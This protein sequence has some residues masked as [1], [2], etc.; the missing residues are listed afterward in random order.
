MAQAIPTKTIARLFREVAFVDDKTR[1]STRTIELA[2]E[3]L[4]L[5]AREA[6]LR[7]N[8]ERAAEA[9]LA[10][11]DGIDNLERKRQLEETA[12]VEAEVDASSQDDFDDDPPVE[13][14]QRGNAFNAAPMAPD[15]T[16]LDVRHLE[17]VAG[18]LLL[19]F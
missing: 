2:A 1:I 12:A 9:A 7:S 17:K 19:D 4:R 11:V 14:T 15:A 16:T 10:V 18:I 6:I 13:D 3:Y 5:F 8:E